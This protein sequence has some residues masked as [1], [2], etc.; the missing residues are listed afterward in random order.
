VLVQ[1][2]LTLGLDIVAEGVE[3]AE[4]LEELRTLGCHHAQGYYFA[5]PMGTGESMAYLATLVAQEPAVDAP[6]VEL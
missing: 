5:T 2:G 6:D 4:Q 3:T 1:L